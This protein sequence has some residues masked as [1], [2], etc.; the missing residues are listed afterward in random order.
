MRGHGYPLV[1]TTASPKRNRLISGFDEILS[2]SLFADTAKV[3]PGTK[4]HAPRTGTS[5]PSFAR[6]GIS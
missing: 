2:G 4:A 3:V 1:E 6:K 5:R